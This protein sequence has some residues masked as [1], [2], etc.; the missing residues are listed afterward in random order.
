MAWQPRKNLVLVKPIRETMSPGGLHLPEDYRA[1]VSRKAVNKPDDFR[2]EVLAVGPDVTDALVRPGAVVQVL[3]W[4]DRADGSR[5]S[6]YSGVDGPDGSLF[7][8]WP[9]DFAG[10]V[11][12]PVPPQAD[13]AAE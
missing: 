8:Y 7:V 6:L 3:T 1:I 13:A 2:A 10:Y 4:S 9:E 11:H 5:R 12:D